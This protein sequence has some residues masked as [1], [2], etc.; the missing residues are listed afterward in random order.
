MAEQQPEVTVLMGVFNGLPRLERSI[1]SILAQTFSNFEFLIIDDASTDGSD[2]VVQQYAKEDCR[3]RLIRNEVNAGLGAVLNLGV[4]EARAALIARMDAD[5]VAVPTRLEKQVAYFRAHPETDILG[6]YA[7]DVGED[8]SI[9]RERRVPTAHDRIVKLI[10]SCPIV[11]PTVMF[12]RSSILRAGSYPSTRRR[13]QDYDLWFRCVAAGLIFA[14][15]PEPLLHYTFSQQTVQKNNFSSA[16]KQVGVGLRGCWLVRAS[17]L[18]YLGTVAPLLEAML[19]D[20][21][22]V[23]LAG[24]KG[25]LDPRNNG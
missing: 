5:D 22:R 6:S 12:R 16:L 13:R 21:L 4:R 20:S 14:N 17:P 24:F 7:L 8:G 11:H 25:K 10:W 23:R 1:R 19:P 18:A 2:Q 3:I 9:I 15:L